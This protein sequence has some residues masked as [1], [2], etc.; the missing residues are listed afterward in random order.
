[1]TQKH[2]GKLSGISVLVVEDDQD[3]RD[4]LGLLLT[5]KGATV[6]SAETVPKALDTLNRMTPDVLLVDIGLPEYNGYV[7]IG[8][9]RSLDDPRKR[10]VP[11]I[12]LTAYS[13]TTDRDTVLTSGFQR[14]IAK[15]FDLGVLVGA[16]ADAA[17]SQKH[18]A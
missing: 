4:L 11:A 17:T 8:R 10:S 1:M 14:Y 18:A 12:A 16:I 6:T 9:V 7:F 15:P 5:N 13:S 3:T 2:D